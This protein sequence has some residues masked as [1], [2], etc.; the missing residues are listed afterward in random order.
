M[1]LLPVRSNSIDRSSNSRIKSSISLEKSGMLDADR[2][3][4]G[5]ERDQTASELRGLRKRAKNTQGQ[6]ATTVA[7]H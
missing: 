3:A 1:L 4:G 2:G 6:S 7:R 5:G